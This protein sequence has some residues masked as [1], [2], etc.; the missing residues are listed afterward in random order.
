MVWKSPVFSC[1]TDWAVEE[2]RLFGV[3]WRVFRPTCSEGTGWSWATDGGIWLW[4]ALVVAPKMFGLA[5]QSCLDKA[6]VFEKN[7]LEE[8]N[9]AKGPRFAAYEVLY[10]SQI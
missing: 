1:P 10:E 6:Q 2:L 9:F 8:T 7:L 3:I 4:Q 5:F